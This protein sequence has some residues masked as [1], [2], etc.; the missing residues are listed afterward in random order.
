[1]KLMKVIYSLPFA[2]AAQAHAQSADTTPTTLLLSSYSTNIVDDAASF[3]E[4]VSKL[5]QRAIPEIRL[6]HDTRFVQVKLKPS[7]GALHADA[8]VDLLRQEFGSSLNVKKVPVEQLIYGSQ[9][10]Y[11]S[12]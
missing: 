1:M 11:T 10:D 8:L 12:N 5:N 7:E 4:L 2:F 3:I 9:D 6:H